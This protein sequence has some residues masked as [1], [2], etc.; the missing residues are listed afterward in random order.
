MNYEAQIAELTMQNAQLKRELDQL[1]KLIFGAKK[2]R[3]VTEN[4]T[5]GQLSLF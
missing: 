1:R 2:E 5:P 3:F 4:V